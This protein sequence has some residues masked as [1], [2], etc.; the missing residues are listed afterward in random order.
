M[1]IWNHVI[2]LG[3]NILHFPPCDIQLTLCNFTIWRDE[4]ISHLTDRNLLELSCR[5]SNVC[6]I[7]CTIRL[8]PGSFTRDMRN[9]GSRKD[10]GKAFTIR[11]VLYLVATF[12]KVF[13]SMVC[14]NTSLESLKGNK[15][16]M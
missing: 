4:Q 9:S 5:S 3:L 16:Q 11:T 10:D 7:S 2:N 12:S 8:I 13:M 14:S 15:N 6:K 1:F